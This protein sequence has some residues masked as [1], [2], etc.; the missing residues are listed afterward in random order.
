MTQCNTLNGKLSNPQFNKLNS[1]I[2]NGTKVALNISWNT[3]GD[4]NH[5]TDFNRELS[6][7]Q[8]LIRSL[9]LILLYSLTSFLR[10]ESEK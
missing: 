5:E 2:R 4:S 7:T 10:K 9:N 3:T 1:G 6:K 8:Q